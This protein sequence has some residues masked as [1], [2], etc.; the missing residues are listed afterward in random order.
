MRIL[1]W[2]T[3]LMV[4]MHTEHHI[5]SFDLESFFRLHDLDMNGFWDEA[6]IEAVYGLHHHSVKENIPQDA[7]R[8]ARA[9]SVVERVL[10]ALDK[11][12]DGQSKSKCSE[13]KLTETGRIS[14][15]EFLAGGTDGLP[16]FTGYKDLGRM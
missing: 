15:E 4:Q 13:V 8:Q 2:G 7:L 1:Q 3:V 5:D 9:H 10:K 12:D 11:N 6:E 14:L 16:S